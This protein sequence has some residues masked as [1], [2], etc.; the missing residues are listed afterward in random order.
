MGRVFKSPNGQIE[1]TDRREAANG[2]SLRSFSDRDDALAFLRMYL[3]DPA[4]LADLRRW[5]GDFSTLNPPVTDILERL[6]TM[7]AAGD[8]ALMTNRLLLGSGSTHPEKPGVDKPDV[9][10]PP[11]GPKPKPK[12]KTTAELVVIVKD[13]DGKPVK[14]ATVTAGAL[15]S[16]KTNESG[17]A[18]YGKVKPGTYDVEAEKEG[19]S[20]KKKGKIREDKKKKVSVPDGSKTTVNLVQHPICAS[21]S[22]FEGPT[23]RSKYF[24]FDHKTDMPATDPG[25]YWKPCPEHGDLTLPGDKMTRDGARWVSVAVGKEVQLEINFDFK[26]KECI[27]CISNSTFEVVPGSVA[28]VLTPKISSKKAVFKIKGKAVGEASLKVICDGHDIGWFHIWCQNEATIKLDVACLVT[29]RAPSTSYSMTALQAHFDDVF[30][31]ACIKIDMLDLGDIDLTGLSALAAIESTGYPASG[32]GKFLSKSGT[33]R[34]YDSK[35]AVLNALNAAASGALAARTTAPLARAGAYRLYWYV[36][37]VGCSILGTVLNIG[38]NRG[39]GFAADSSTAR[40]SCAHE[41]GHSLNLRHPS[42]GNSTPQYAPHL[43][44]TLNAAVPAFPA[45]N[46]EPASA[47]QAAFVPTPKRASNNVLGNDPTNLMGYWSDRPNR[48][49][50]RYNQWKTISRS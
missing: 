28:E 16:M 42:D 9:P 12:D 35:G 48:K 7:I 50:L 23:S 49:R 31:Q 30:R 19:H 26:H 32:G 4:V 44:A 34:P 46:T 47:A 27:P 25:H 18:D 41:F 37:T 6:A 14:D 2:Q 13:A 29:N 11:P 5:A 43:L 24:G 38:S 20:D 22:F 8:L 15:G 36:P 45:T 10:P 21:V 39:F 40:N 17:I 33:P 1:L 3:S